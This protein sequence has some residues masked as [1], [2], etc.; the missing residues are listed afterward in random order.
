MHPSP[1]SLTTSHRIFLVEDH[2]FVR[3][4]VTR[5]L[6]SEPDLQVCGHAG[7]LP[8]ALVRLRMLHADI[9]IIE[10][11]LPGPNGLELIKHLRTEQPRLRILVFSVHDEQLYGLRAFRAGASGYLMKSEHAPVLVQA[12]RQILAGGLHVSPHLGGDFV[13]KS[14]T[15]VARES[16]SPV[17]AL[18]D[19]ELEVLH[20]IGQG[21]SSSEIATTLSLSLKTVETHRLHIRSKLTLA[22]SA[23]LVRFA[24]HFVS[25]QRGEA[26]FAPCLEVRSSSV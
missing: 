13:H 17:A 10:I 14:L 23:E 9:A 11:D 26:P 7:S 20:H 24:L 5:L 25:Q 4:G 1:A 15:R 21:K 22:S 8:E 19:R 3:Y 18:T 2:P 6:E 12:V 16:Q